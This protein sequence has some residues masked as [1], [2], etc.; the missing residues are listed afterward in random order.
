METRTPDNQW[1][2]PEEA[3]LRGR[4]SALEGEMVIVIAGIKSLLITP[5]GL[6]QN[7]H[8]LLTISAICYKACFAGTAISHHAGPVRDVIPAKTAHNTS[9]KVTSVKRSGF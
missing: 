8:Y 3:L 9:C 5:L 2:L 7:S 1:N 4:R 6:L